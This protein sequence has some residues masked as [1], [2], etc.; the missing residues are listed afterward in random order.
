MFR[1]NWLAGSVFFL[2][3]SAVLLA[4]GIV[5][6]TQRPANRRI[7]AV[8]QRDP[9]ANHSITGREPTTPQQADPMNDR[10]NPFRKAIT[11]NYRVAQTFARWTSTFCRI[12]WPP[13]TRDSL[14]SSRTSIMH[15]TDCVDVHARGLTSLQGE[16][17]IAEAQFP[18][19][20]TRP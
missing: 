13:A 6:R 4:V 8:R 16:G 14:S 5:A 1:R 10:T 3:L 9:I 7:D 12:L 17:Y 18:A 2:T 20:C 15:S 11:G 19:K